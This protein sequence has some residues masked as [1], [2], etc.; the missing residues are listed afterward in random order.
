MKRRQEEADE[1]LTGFEFGSGRKRSERFLSIPIATHTS[2]VK[3]DN[4]KKKKPRKSVLLSETKKDQTT[5]S[6]ENSQKRPEQQRL[7][8]F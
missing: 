2:T 3:R 5:N 8:Q 7:V 6:L 1:D 4:T